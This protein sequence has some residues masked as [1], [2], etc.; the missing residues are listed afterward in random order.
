MKICV[1]RMNII[2]FTR[3]IIEFAD[4]RVLDSKWIQ[5]LSVRSRNYVK[6]E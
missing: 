2:I 1:I 3:Q 4:R 5:T 6:T